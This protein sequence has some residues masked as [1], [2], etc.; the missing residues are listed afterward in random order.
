MDEAK[1][2]RSTHRRFWEYLSEIMNE[3][4]LT[5]LEIDGVKFWPSIANDGSGWSSDMCVILVEGNK[6][7]TVRFSIGEGTLKDADRVMAEIEA[8]AK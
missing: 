2:M 3:S 4:E 5:F 1:P 6:S 7:R 8:A